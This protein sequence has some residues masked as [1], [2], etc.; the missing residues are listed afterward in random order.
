MIIK[1]SEGETPKVVTPDDEE[2]E[3]LHQK[4]SELAD[5]QVHKKAAEETK[6]FWVK[7]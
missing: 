3:K 5:K 2:K 1:Y 6:P 4:V 7:E